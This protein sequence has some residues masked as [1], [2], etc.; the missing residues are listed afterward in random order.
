MWEL[1]ENLMQGLWTQSVCFFGFVLW[2]AVVYLLQF[3]YYLLAM[4]LILGRFF[5]AFFSYVFSCLRLSIS[6]SNVVDQ[7]LIYL[8]IWN[9]LILHLVDRRKLNSETFHKSPV[10]SY[11]RENYFF[12]ISIKIIAS[13]EPS[14]RFIDMKT[15]FV[16]RSIVLRANPTVIL[17]QNVF[18][19]EIQLLVGSIC[20]PSLNR[21]RN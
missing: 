16:L 15:S 5:N 3:W 11:C 6:S 4:N 12:Q 9:L 7:W 2:L 19:R 10:P 1:V 8:L 13:R 17:L 20:A 18:A 21:K 14:L